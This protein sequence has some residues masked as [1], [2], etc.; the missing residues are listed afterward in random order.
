MSLDIAQVPDQ[1]TRES[2]RS[3]SD[4]L[5]YSGPTMPIRSQRTSRSNVTVGADAAVLG[6]VEND[7]RKHFSPLIS[8]PLVVL[9]GEVVLGQVLSCL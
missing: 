9:R 6:P 1:R 8:Q 2:S 4:A 7:D 3:D 5:C